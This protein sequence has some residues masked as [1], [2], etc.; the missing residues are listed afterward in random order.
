MCPHT[1][2]AC[3]KSGSRHSGTLSVCFWPCNNPPDATSQL[4]TLPSHAALQIRRS[5]SA[6]AASVRAFGPGVGAVLSARA[7]VAPSDGATCCSTIV[8]A[9]GTGTAASV[10][11]TSAPCACLRRFLL[12]S[13]DVAKRASDGTSHSATEP[14]HP[15]LST[16]TRSAEAVGATSTDETGDVWCSSSAAWSTGTVLLSWPGT[17]HTA[18]V[19]DILP[20]TTASAPSHLADVN[21]TDDA[22]AGVYAYGSFC[23][24]SASYTRTI[25]SYEAVK[26]VPGRPASTD[27]TQSSCRAASL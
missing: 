11:T 13:E 21:E 2:S 8:G 19:P 14:S 7:A 26:I 4:L 5:P 22:Y 12:P 20:V 18:T 25:P 16:A 6:N 1:S 9:D 24:A 27:A 10:S 23:K 15:A 17:R 3:A